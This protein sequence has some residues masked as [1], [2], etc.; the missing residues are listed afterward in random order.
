MMV[1]FWRRA[2]ALI[3]V[4]GL[5]C[6]A[7]HAATPKISDVLVP[8]RGGAIHLRVHAGGDRTILLEAG[9]GDGA[10]SWNDL[11]PRIAAATG[12]TVVTY[13]RSNT[14]SSAILTTSYDIH[15]EVGRIHAALYALGLHKSLILVGHSY[16]G[17]MITLHSNLYPEAVHGLV[18]VD[19]N[20]VRSIDAR[21]PHAMVARHKNRPN[22]ATQPT[23][24]LVGSFVETHEMMRRYPPVCGVPV[25]VIDAENGPNPS[26]TKG[27]DGWAEGHAEQ[28]RMTGGKL[29]VAKGAGHMVHH[30]QPDLV[31][32]EI[33][34]VY[35][36]APREGAKLGVLGQTCAAS[37]KDP[38]NVPVWTPVR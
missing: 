14:G 36:A 6:T 32:Q 11:A 23:M 26:V 35:R 17:Y 19:A 10:E 4:W 20:T 13:D 33:V 8:V 27:K 16:G 30:E 9:Q 24:R 2:L 12:A 1:G 28:A 31:L 34:A 5:A 15:D 18:Y 3:G 38:A 7:V 22:S 25:T 21:D 29:V 37:M